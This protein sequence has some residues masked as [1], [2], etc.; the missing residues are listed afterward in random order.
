MGLIWTLDRR[1]HIQ[2]IER[3][4]C[5]RGESLI[6]KGSLLRSQDYQTSCNARMA[7]D[8]HHPL[9]Q[10]YDPLER[11][12]NSFIITSKSRLYNQQFSKVYFLRLSQLRAILTEAC[13]GRWK[14][15]KVCRVLDITPSGTSVVVGTIYCEMKLK[16]NVLDDLA[17]E[18]H[19]G[20]VIGLRK[21]V[22][23]NEDSVMLEDESGRV[24]LVGLDRQRWCLVTGI[25]VGVLG[26]ETSKGDF[27]VLDVVY[28]GP[29]PQHK[30]QTP[31]ANQGLVAIVS[32]LDLDGNKS[33]RATARCDALI[34]WLSGEV[35]GKEERMIAKSVGRLIIAGNLI[36]IP[37][38]HD[39]RP[40]NDEKK[41]RRYGYDPSTYTGVPTDHADE[42]LSQLDLPVDLMPGPHDPT[43]QALPQQP[44]HKCLLP[45][46]N[47]SK[48]E[49]NLVNGPN[50]W[51]A[52]I[53]GTTF[54]GTSGQNLDD[55]YKY[56]THEDRLQLAAQ[57]L[58]WSHIAPTAPDTLWCYPF[59]E[60]D[61]FILTE[62]PGVYFIGN[63]PKFETKL[64]EF[65]SAKGDKKTRLILVPR[66]SKSGTIVLVDPVTLKCQSVHLLRDLPKG[67]NDFDEEDDGDEAMPEKIVM[68]VDADDE[69]D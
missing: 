59:Q 23:E 40:N 16:P 60:E 31:P 45:L 54:L 44:L 24:R 46:A 8:T 15:N 20:P 56:V 6:L 2:R 29:P 9:Q 30:P 19:I 36:W 13:E 22:T 61:P 27:E 33:A 63:Q 43:I 12:R 35:G 14:D 25:T 1:V 57:M 64:V 39:N 58:E 67:L 51:W 55:I 62:L 65:P 50:P 11:R 48:G 66:F 26:R 21:W 3:L 10:S 68:D 42:V 53:G 37:S 5:A 34:E 18:H 47:D 69:D 32:G 4:S 38:S 52:E 17:R 41:P 49:R 28:A 7:I